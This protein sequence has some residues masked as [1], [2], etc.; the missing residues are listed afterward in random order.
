M[1]IEA[2]LDD[3][4]H[5]QFARPLKLRHT[6]VRVLVTLPDD[7]IEEGEEEAATSEPEPH[8]PYNGPEAASDFIDELQS[9]QAPIRD[10]LQSAENT[11][12]SKDEMRELRDQAWEEKHRG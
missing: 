7:E 10:V 6:R 5:L 12:L 11:S 8:I 1:K 3:K 2:T 4:G 9:I